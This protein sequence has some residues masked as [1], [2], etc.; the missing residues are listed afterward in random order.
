MQGGIGEGLLRRGDVRRVL[1]DGQETFWCLSQRDLSG[2]LFFLEQERRGVTGV[3]EGGKEER[4]PW[5]SFPGPLQASGG[6]GQPS[7]V[8]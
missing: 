2:I 4:D 3:G 8:I 6:V 1:G 7:G 5:F